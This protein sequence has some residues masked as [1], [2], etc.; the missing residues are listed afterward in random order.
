M[1]TFNTLQQTP[2]SLNLLRIVLMVAI[3]VAIYYIY[4]Y[5]F[6]ADTVQYTRLVSGV[7][8]A[9]N[10]AIANITADKLPPL[11][12]GGEY[13][14]SCWLYINDMSYLN[15]YFK[16]IFEIGGD[17]FI[18][19]MVGLGGYKNKL[20][21]RV[22]SAGASGDGSL[23]TVATHAS[24]GTREV[25]S[26]LGVD[27]NMCELPNVDMQ[28]WIL[29]TVVITG[30]ICD[31]YIDGK[32][33]RSCTLPNFFRVDNGYSVKLFSKNVSGSGTATTALG[34]GFGGYISN[35]TAYGYS[36]NPGDIYKLY[37]SGPNAGVG[38]LDWFK[39]FFTPDVVSLYPKMNGQ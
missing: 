8:P 25:E 3:F 27:N 20:I 2:G 11:Y 21:V 7:V 19:L 30:R 6:T 22:N 12:E 38:F 29:L 16:H 18:T 34:S 35:L 36:L 15:G 17:N 23:P 32:L 39:S 37:M 26:S 1:N 33:A 31:I 28:R 14:M 24:M 9:K 5:F 13:S 10:N 4:R